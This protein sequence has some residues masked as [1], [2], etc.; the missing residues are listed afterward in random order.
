MMGISMRECSKTSWKEEV[1]LHDGSKIIVERAVSRGGRHEIGQL[2]PIEDQTIAFHLDKARKQV[3]W[4][5]EFS[6]EFGLAELMPLAIDIHKG[7]AYIVAVPA[8]CRAFNKWGRPNP[9][10][11]VFRYDDNGW[12]RVALVE[13][14]IELVT[15]NLI[16]SSPDEE[17][18]QLGNVSVVS[19]ETVMTVIAG[20]DQPE[21]KTILREPVKGGEGLINCYGK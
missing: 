5:S 11:V 9:P 10:Y 19:A 21:Y 14:P 2:P 20:Y 15:P 16:F 1:L 7:T 3:T 8:G 4:K 17:V 6:K 13:L 18:N 12:K